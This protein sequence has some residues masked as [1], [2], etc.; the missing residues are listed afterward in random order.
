M[1]EGVQL[2]DAGATTIAS[3]GAVVGIFFFSRWAWRSIG[4]PNF[5]A[6]EESCFLTLTGPVL[7]V[8]WTS[9]QTTSST[10]NNSAGQRVFIGCGIETKVRLLLVVPSMKKVDVNEKLHN[11]LLGAR[12]G[13]AG[14]LNYPL[15]ED[16]LTEVVGA[17]NYAL[18]D[19]GPTFNRIYNQSKNHVIS[20]G[21]SRWHRFGYCS[22]QIDGLILACVLVFLFPGFSPGYG[23]SSGTNLGD[24]YSYSG[25]PLHFS[26]STMKQPQLPLI[27]FTPSGKSYPRLRYYH[28]HSQ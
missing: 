18:M 13:V 27:S 10:S 25:P 8:R 7:L 3:T 22:T 6:D 14:A 20:Y 21:T 26:S 12:Y 23:P 17:L 28:M 4:N 15:M 24:S 19:D 11:V 9:S 5:F 1:L 16:G 2:I